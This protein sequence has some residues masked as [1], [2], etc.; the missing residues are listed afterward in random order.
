MYPWGL[1]VTFDGSVLVADSDNNRVA[2]F[3]KKG[4][5]VHSIAVENPIGLTIDS[6]GDL[7]VASCRKKGERCLLLLIT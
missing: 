5:L 2:V 7:L 3:D 6:R 4:E 1:T